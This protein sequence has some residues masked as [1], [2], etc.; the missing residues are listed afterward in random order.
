MWPRLSPDGPSIYILPSVSYNALT[1]DNP[2]VW[3]KSINGIDGAALVE[4]TT[5][6]D[7]DDI[8]SPGFVQGLNQGPCFAFDFS[9]DG[10]RDLSVDEKDYAHYALCSFGPDAG[11]PLNCDCFDADGDGDLDLADFA[12]FQIVFD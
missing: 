2:L 12:A 3:G 5:V 11:M 4:L 1:N 8:G 6:Y 9:H 10:N 7:G